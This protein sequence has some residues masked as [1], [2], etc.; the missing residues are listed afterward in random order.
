MRRPRDRRAA[1]GRAAT[2][3]GPVRTDE[4]QRP[5]LDAL[6]ALGLVPHH[7][8]RLAQARRFFLQAAAIGEDERGPLD[9]LHRHVV[10]ERLDEFDA[11]HLAEQRPHDGCHVR[12]RMDGQEDLRPLR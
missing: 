5:R 4:F 8:N 1:G 3:A 12:A 7:E 6:G 9:G 11:R 10:G 2:I